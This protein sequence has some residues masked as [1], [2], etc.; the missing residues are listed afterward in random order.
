[1]HSPPH[2]APVMRFA[3]KVNIAAQMMSR[4]VA[5]F[6]YTLL[7]RGEIEQRSIATAT[8]I[9]EVDELFDSFNGSQKTA[10]DGKPL[11]CSIS[12]TSEHTGYW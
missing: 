8:F 7:S 12:C 1:M 9:Q 10:P 11:K 3:M 5:A 2:L 4:T 6:L